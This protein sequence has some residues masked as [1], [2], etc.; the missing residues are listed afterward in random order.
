MFI[1]TAR[2]SKKRAIL[3]LT[4]LLA[5][6]ALLAAVFCSPEDDPQSPP[7][8]KD[9]EDRVIYLNSLGWEVS[10]EPLETLEL[11]LPEPLP[12]DYLPYNQIQLAQGYDLNDY[13]GRQLTRYTYKVL[14][15]PDHPDNVQLNLYL[16]GDEIAAGDVI[17]SGSHGFQSGLLFPQK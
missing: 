3:I 15:Y 6:A 10:P 5:A 4:A 1:V 9:N 8:L 17:A 12:A 11:L 13:C 2:F 7:Q 16:C 14:N